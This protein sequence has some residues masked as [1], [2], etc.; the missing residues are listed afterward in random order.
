MI[1]SQVY[2]TKEERHFLSAYS[3]ETG[4]TQSELIREAIDNY[5]QAQHQQK[6]TFA[7]ILRATKGMWKSRKDLPDFDKLRSEWDRNLPQHEDD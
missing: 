1:R 5:I 7:H 6:E 4:R 3:R 2:L